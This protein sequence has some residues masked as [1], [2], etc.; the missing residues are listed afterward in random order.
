MAA[1]AILPSSTFAPSNS[2]PATQQPAEHLRATSAASASP[3]TSNNRM[4][5]PTRRTATA[6]STIHKSTSSAPSLSAAAQTGHEVVATTDA[7]STASLHANSAPNRAH[8]DSQDAAHTT[9][10]LEPAKEGAAATASA[11]PTGAALD[12]AHSN[13]HTAAPPSLTVKQGKR[14]ASGAQDNTPNENDEQQRKQAVDKILKR[15]QAAKLART[16]RN[17][18]ALASFKAQRGWQNA[19]FGSIESHV[20]QHHHHSMS[21]APSQLNVPYPQAMPPPPPV[22]YNAAAAY[23]QTYPVAP[24]YPPH[25]TPQSA[26][27][28]STS[29]APYSAPPSQPYFGEPQHRQKRRMTVSDATGRDGSPNRRQ[30]SVAN[31]NRARATSLSQSSVTNGHYAV[32]STLQHQQRQQPNTSRPLS[33]SDPTFSSF[34]DAAQALTGLSRGPSDHSVL[35]GEDEQGPRSTSRPTA[36]PATP[37]QERPR[38]QGVGAGPGESS[39]EG[40][41][42]LMLFLAAS[43][44][45]VQTNKMTASTSAL[46]GDGAPLKGRRLFSGM[47]GPTRADGDINSSVSS[48]GIALNGTQSTSF[49]GGSQ[50]APPMSTSTSMQSDEQ[51]NPQTSRPFANNEDVVD[52]PSKTSLRYGAVASSALGSAPPLMASSGPSGSL[53]G[54]PPMPSTPSRD[55]QA[56]GSGWEHFLNVSPSPQRPT[57]DR[58][59]I[60]SGGGK[61][62]DHDMPPPT[63]SASTTS[64]DLLEG[65]SGP[66]PFA[67]A[68][69]TGALQSNW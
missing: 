1:A 38:G 19:D 68:S 21:Q 28:A 9:L 42:E 4:P 13:T 50:L 48:S 12:S 45:P 23:A 56:S 65:R 17:R 34:V 22:A 62:L 61:L 58:S 35:S 67:T 33:S 11:S 2:V 5:S 47:D 31:G 40:A 39:A 57:F 15:A 10:E 49:D 52:G 20:S 24:A 59:A 46:G 16:F 32:P 44:S 29:A 63:T 41:A 27:Y 36:R 54:L 6:A 14:S 55:R 37:E 8:H 26:P 43:P 7:R 64:G 18:I 66:S 3:F 30:A 51:Q 69:T 25:T 60:G 53:T